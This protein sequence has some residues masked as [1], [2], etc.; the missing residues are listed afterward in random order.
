MPAGAAAI[1]VLTE[2]DH[3]GGSMDDLE[4][5]RR[6]RRGAG[7]QRRTS[8]V[9]PVQLYRSACAWRVGGAADRREPFRAR[10]LVELHDRG[11]AIGL[12][13]LVE[14]RDEEELALAL[15][16]GAAI[17]GVN[18]RNLESLVID[19]STVGRVVPLIPRDVIA[20]AES[21]MA[22]RRGCAAGRSRGRRRCAGGVICV[23]R[24]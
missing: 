8:I 11:T 10:A 19:P 2:P 20:I 7:A 13:L 21:G 18:N 3:F 4:A 12:E 5:V 24:A 9:A 1:S 22:S 23:R 16:I 14:V 17:I 15:D 6:G